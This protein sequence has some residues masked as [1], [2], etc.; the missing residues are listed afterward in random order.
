MVEF[1]P[2]DPDDDEEFGRLVA[3]RDSPPT[4]LA[5]AEEVTGALREKWVNVGMVQA[6]YHD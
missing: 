3:T 6:E 2:L 5:S 4:A 1:P